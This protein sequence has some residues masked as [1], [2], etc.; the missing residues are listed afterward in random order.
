MKRITFILVGF[1]LGIATIA[2]QNEYV[3]KTSQQKSDNMSE[4]EHFTETNFPLKALCKWT[5]GLKF[6][7]IPDGNDMFVPIFSSYETEKEV[8]SSKLKHKIFEF[9]GTEEKQR[10][11]YVGTNYSTRF[12]FTCE[13]NKYY[14][15]FKGQRLDDICTQNPRASI[16][17]LVYLTDVDIA[18]NL[19]IG[20]VVYNKFN[21]ARIDDSN[22]YSG[23]K[24][25]NIPKDEKMTIT[26]I[27]VGSKSYPVKIIFEDTKGNSYYVEVALSRTNSGMDKSD[28]QADKRMKYFPNA[29]SFNNQQALTLE[30]LK[31]KYIGMPVYPKQTMSVKCYINTE[32]K[33]TENWVRLL[34]YTSLHIKDIDVKLPKTEAVLTLED[35]NGSIFEVEADLKYDII[36]KNDN[37]IEDIF[38]FGDIRKKYP[39]TTEENWKLISQ[40]EVQQGMTTDECRLALG[41]PIQIEFKQDTR[42][43]TWLYPRKML[44]FES[45]RLLRYK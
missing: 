34:R 37:Y 24:T 32:G 6:M 5:P 40:G 7:F 17:G 2:A 8:D 27:G 43:E 36:T 12:I 9:Q 29:F 3:V 13:G 25:V 26:N 18:R 20:R 14:Y 28:F 22:S 45:G 33:S 38:A 21:I 44:E 10:E 15:E 35:T 4:E 30:N 23:Y 1:I 42:F 19:L 39:H 31:E 11:T 16:N 41:N